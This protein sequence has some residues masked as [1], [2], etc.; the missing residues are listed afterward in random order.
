MPGK[1]VNS[2]NSFIKKYHLDAFKDVAIFMIILVIFHFLWKQFVGDFFSVAAIS[3]SAYWLANMV[4]VQSNWLLGLFDVNVTPFEHLS[5]DGAVKQNVFYYAENNGYVSVNRSCSGMKQFYQ[6]FF[7]MVLYPGPWKHKLWFIPFGLFTIHVV[8]VL[9]IITMVLIT[10]N[11]PEHWDFV[12]D[13]V[14]RPF[15]YVVMFALWVWWNER[16]YLKKKTVPAESQSNN[17]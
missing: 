4:Y 16:F 6:W 1:L 13:Y 10:I 11:L 17:N 5:I 9:R 8:N 15:F 2:I 12:H 14:V 3:N 7:L